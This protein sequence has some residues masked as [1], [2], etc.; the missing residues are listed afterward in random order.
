M[1]LSPPGRQ[2]KKQASTLG[3]TLFLRRIFC[4]KKES[5]LYKLRKNV[6]DALGIRNAS[7]S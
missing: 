3:V 5:N 7:G 1:I 4:G 6:V 2:L